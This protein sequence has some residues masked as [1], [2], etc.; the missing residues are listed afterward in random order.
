MFFEEDDP[1][2]IHR[3][4]CTAVLFAATASL[5]SN[6]KFLP[7]RVRVSV[8]YGFQMIFHQEQQHRLH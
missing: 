4:L 6:P 5:V 3:C 1:D 7:A 8:S 2:H